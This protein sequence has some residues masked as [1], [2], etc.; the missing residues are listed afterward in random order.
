ME[1]PHEGPSLVDI[2]PPG[3]FQA[4]KLEREELVYKTDKEWRETFFRS[5]TQTAEF[6]KAH[7]GLRTLKGIS[8]TTH[9]FFKNKFTTAATVMG[10]IGSAYAGHLVQDIDNVVKNSDG[11]LQGLH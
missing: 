6:R 7:L 1:T 9:A 8:D 11:I 3:E 4:P 5:Y 10:V 2:L